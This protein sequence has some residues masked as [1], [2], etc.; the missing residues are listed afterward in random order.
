MQDLHAII[1]CLHTVQNVLDETF[2][3]T[4]TKCSMRKL[5]STHS[6]Y[7]AKKIMNPH[8]QKSLQYVQT[9][10][11][12]SRSCFVLSGCHGTFLALPSSDCKRG[13]E[14][15]NDWIYFGVELLALFKEA[16]KFFVPTMR[17]SQFLSELPWPEHTLLSS[18]SNGTGIKRKINGCINK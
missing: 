5:I 15:S 2:P 1:Y 12:E 4:C 13:R 18:S 7:G 6:A 3:K 9:E 14:V 8:I 11:S 10:S 16:Y 17:I